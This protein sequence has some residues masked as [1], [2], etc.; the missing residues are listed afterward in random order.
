MSQLRGLLAAGIVV[1]FALPSLAQSASATPGGGP[2]DAASYTTNP[3]W[4]AA[5]REGKMYLRE[6]KPQFAKDDFNKANKI[7]GGACWD[8]LDGLYSAQFAEGDY[9]G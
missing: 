9:K 4:V 3:K 1:I 2:T 8:C 5:M 6:Q 7:A